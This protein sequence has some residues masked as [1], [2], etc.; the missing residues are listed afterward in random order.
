MQ[1]PCLPW[2]IQSVHERPIPAND[3]RP[4]N[5]SPTRRRRFPVHDSVLNGTRVLYPLPTTAL[6]LSLSLGPLSR[7]RERERIETRTLRDRTAN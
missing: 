3:G 1:V 5:T 6:S 7:E 4:R 2:R